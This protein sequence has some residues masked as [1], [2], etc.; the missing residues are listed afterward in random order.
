MTM[1]A[2]GHIRRFATALAVAIISSGFS[3]W[4]VSAIDEDRVLTADGP[5]VFYNQDGSVSVLSV[6]REGSVSDTTYIDGLPEGFSVHVE[7]QSGKYVFDVPLAEKDR[8]EWDHRKARKTFI[9]SDPHGRMDLMVEL[10]KSH[11]VIDSDLEWSFGR[12]HLVVLGD[13]FDRGE[14]V[15]QILWLLYKLESEAESAGGRLSFMLGNHETM[16]LAGDLRYVEDKYVAIADSVDVTIPHLYGSDTELGRWLSTRNTI[17]RIDDLLLVHA[18]LG[19]RMLELAMTA[20]QVNDAMSAGLFQDKASRKADPLGRILF[21]NPGPVWYRGLVLDKEKYDPIS[22]EHLE[23]ILDLYDAD[24]IIVGHTIMDDITVLHGG[25]V[26]AVNVNNLENF[27]NDLGRAVL[28]RGRRI[29]VV[30][31]DTL[32]DRLKL[33]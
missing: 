21:S 1:S 31:N 17:E 23:E 8:P 15:T 5:Y 33:N 18:G 16:V 30:G 20:P 11:K 26:I 22:E 2:S 3:A 28:V 32:K 4:A 7:D 25:R 24:R 14:D 13:V 12:N 29:Y 27:V 19:P 9:L 6:T 10:L